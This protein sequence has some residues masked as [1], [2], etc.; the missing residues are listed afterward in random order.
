MACRHYSFIKL[1][2]RPS[3]QAGEVLIEGN[4]VRKHVWEA[5]KKASNRSWHEMYVIVKGNLLLAYKDSKAAKSSPDSYYKGETPISL[6]G[7]AVE[8]ATDYTKKKHVF[9]IKLTNG[10]EYLMQAKDDD[11]MRRWVEALGRATE[12]TAGTSRAQTLPAGAVPEKGE[13]KRRSFFTLKHS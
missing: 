2:Q 8:V 4:L 10:S 13:G 3:P 5:M 7:A 11:E 6:S 12:A 9:K 1:S